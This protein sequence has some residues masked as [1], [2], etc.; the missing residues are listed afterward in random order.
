MKSVY[1]AV[2]TGSLNK[3]LR[4]VFKS[5]KLLPLAFCITCSKRH[6]QQRS[7]CL[8]HSLSHDM[9]IASAKASSLH[10][11]I[12]FFLFQCTVSSRF[13]KSVHQLHTSSLPSSR[14]F[15]PA[16]YFYYNKVFQK[17]VSTQNAS[18]PVSLPSVYCMQDI[19]LHFD[20]V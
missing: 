15:Y 19:Q 14:H 10:S 7:K 6:S 4:F 5:L 12:Q 2:R 16:L 17:A 9:S 3:A 13:R 1:S 11:A 18:N 8:F 20:C